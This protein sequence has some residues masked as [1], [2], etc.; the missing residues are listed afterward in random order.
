MFAMV[1]TLFLWMYWS[2]TSQMN[3]PARSAREAVLIR[4]RAHLHTWA[5]PGSALERRPRALVGTSV[6]PDSSRCC[7]HPSMLT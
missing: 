5:R 1:G 2:V 6:S 3:V 7:L 4:A